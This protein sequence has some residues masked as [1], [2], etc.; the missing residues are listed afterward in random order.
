MQVKRPMT[1]HDA[2]AMKA[3]VLKDVL[4]D[5]MRNLGKSTK[6]GDDSSRLPVQ[7]TN[8]Q[9]GVLADHQQQND[10]HV[11][12]QPAAVS[13]AQPAGNEC[14]AK[15]PAKPPGITPNRQRLGCRT[16]PVDNQHQLQQ[17]V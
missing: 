2:Q 11:G 9:W 15:W 12:G 5:V 16:N 4:S 17:P 1:P 13:A 14:P 6:P 3:E 10:L 8:T 7:Y